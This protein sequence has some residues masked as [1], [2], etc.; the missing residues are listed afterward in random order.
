MKN[1]RYD[2]AREVASKSDATIERETASK[3]AARTLACYARSTA[4]KTVH[5][6]LKWR[7]RAKGYR[8]EALEHAALVGDG[9]KTVKKIQRKLDAAARRNRSRTKRK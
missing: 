8:D 6:Q 4:A 1:T 3:W 2:A 5:E 9:G 7:E